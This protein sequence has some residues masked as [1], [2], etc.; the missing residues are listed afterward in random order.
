LET[1][2]RIGRRDTYRNIDRE[3]A[4]GI[5]RSLPPLTTDPATPSEE[6]I[7]ASLARLRGLADALPEGPEVGERVIEGLRGGGV[8]SSRLI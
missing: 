2:R 3:V 6:E 1:V 4:A 7:A 8:C 5:V